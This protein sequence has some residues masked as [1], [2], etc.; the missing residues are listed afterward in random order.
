VDWIGGTESMVAGALVAGLLCG[1]AAPVLRRRIGWVGAVAWCGLAWWLVVIGLVTLVPLSGIDLGIPAE[2]RADTCSLDYGGPAPE[3]FWI[4]SGTQRLL[5]TA[6]FV[7]AGALLVIAAARWRIGWVIA[8]LG[9]LLLGGYSLAIELA[10]LEV[11][12][13]DRAC[14]VTDVVDNVTGAA[15]GFVI[16]LLLVPVLRPWRHD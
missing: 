8:P 4:F 10:Q 1:L 2:A 6:L 11:A 15:I 16:G 12:R 9:L 13:I 5:N 14:D 7:P 3:G